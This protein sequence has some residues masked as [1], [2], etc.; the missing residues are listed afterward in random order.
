M[1]TGGLGLFKSPENPKCQEQ[2]FVFDRYSG[3]V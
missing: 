2:G 1:S 3:N